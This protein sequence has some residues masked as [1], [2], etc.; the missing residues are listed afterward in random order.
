MKSVVPLNSRLILK[1]EPLYI[2]FK[3]RAKQLK[4]HYL[5]SGNGL[6]KNYLELFQKGEELLD[7]Q[8]EIFSVSSRGLSRFIDFNR[9]LEKE[10]RI[11]R[12]NYRIL[13]KILKKFSIRIQAEF[14]S[15]YVLDVSRRDALRQ[16]LFKNNVFLPIHWPR[17]SQT[18]NQLYDRVLSIPLDSRYNPHDM[19]FVARKIKEF[20]TQSLEKRNVR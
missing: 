1:K 4:Y 6:A 3:Y 17:F 15:F 18:H 19:K 13:D 12:E 10:G 14:Y 8:R 2:G 7:R 9:S 11:R 16:Y 5:Q 20:L